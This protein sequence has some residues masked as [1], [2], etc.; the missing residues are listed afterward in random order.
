MESYWLFLTN[1]F[2]LVLLLSFSHLYLVSVLCPKRQQMESLGPAAPLQQITNGFQ[3][4]MA[5]AY[6]LQ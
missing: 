1:I 5:M 3:L 4:H 2:A 6:L